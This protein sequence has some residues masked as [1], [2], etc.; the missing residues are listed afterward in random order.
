MAK[1]KKTKTIKKT[2][3]TKRAKNLKIKPALKTTEK[4]SSVSGQEDKPEIKKL[5][6]NQ[7]K[8]GSII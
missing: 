2:K 4:K 7:L 1:K 3:K 8:K 6:N 5:K